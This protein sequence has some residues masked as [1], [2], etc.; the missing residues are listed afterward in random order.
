MFTARIKGWIFDK[1]MKG[2]ND[3]ATPTIECIIFLFKFGL[4]NHFYNCIH[5]KKLKLL[6]IGKIFQ[7]IPMV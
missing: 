5:L 6:L 7:I 3:T 1:K 2:L 4:E